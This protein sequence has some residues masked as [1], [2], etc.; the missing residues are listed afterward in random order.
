MNVWK[1]YV[2][3]APTLRDHSS[4]I[5]L[6]EGLYLWAKPLVLVSSVFM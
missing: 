5:A 3:T 2:A 1:M 6:M 4:A